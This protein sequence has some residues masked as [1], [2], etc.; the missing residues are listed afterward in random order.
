MAV[1]V[2]GAGVGRTGTHS[3]KIALEQLVGGRCYHMIEVFGLPE[4]VGMWT[5]AANGDLPDWRAVLADFDAVVD[6]P[7]CS[8]W[9]EL[10]AA[11]PD[12]PVLLSTRSPESWWQSASTT[13]FEVL[14]EGLETSPGFTEMIEAIFSTRFTAEVFDRDAAIAAYERHNAEVRAS[15]PA[16]RLIEWS[17]GDG[18]APLCEGLGL[19]VPAE[20][21]PHVNTSAEFRAMAGLDG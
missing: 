4:H 18:W 12:A 21:F 6:W 20:P 7:A 15:V 9:P 11:Y 10:A 14:R 17:P 5:A 3:L 2:V 19:P 1:Q 13:I 8:F 16:G